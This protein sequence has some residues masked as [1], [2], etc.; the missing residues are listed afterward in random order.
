MSMRRFIRLSNGFSTKLENHMH[1]VSLHSAWPLTWQITF[2]QRTREFHCCET[3]TEPLPKIGLDLITKH[4]D[5][6]IDLVDEV[7]LPGNASPFN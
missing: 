1:T 5:V 4:F 3:E 6:A 7:G 2:G